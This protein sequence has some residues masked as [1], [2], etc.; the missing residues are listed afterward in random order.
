MCGFCCCCPMHEHPAHPRGQCQ[1]W[2]RSC[3]SF[4]RYAASRSD[5][6]LP[7][8]THGW[9]PQMPLLQLLGRCCSLPAWPACCMPLRSTSCRVAVVA[10]IQVAQRDWKQRISSV[11]RNWRL[12]GLGGQGVKLGE[13]F[14]F[15][16]AIK[17]MIRLGTEEWRQDGKDNVQLGLCVT[18]FS[19]APA[20]PAA[21][22]ASPLTIIRTLP[23]HDAPS[24][25]GNRLDPPATA[26]TAAPG[27]APPGLQSGLGAA[28]NA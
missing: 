5:P 2:G 18:L 4:P 16:N 10:L 14:C 28:G 26:T 20:T 12:G 24:R 8:G 13:L 7:C 9:L 25:L 11:S 23:A 15:T 22:P 1:H 6:Q 19:A 17:M 21:A 3:Q 27:A